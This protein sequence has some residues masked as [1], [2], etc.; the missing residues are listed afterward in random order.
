M[1]SVDGD[2][3]TGSTRVVLIVD[4]DTISRMLLQHMVSAQGYEV[5]EADSVDPALAVLE[6]TAVDLIICDYVMPGKDGLDL[7]ETMPD[8]TIPFV[9]LTGALDES[10][11]NDT[12]VERVSAYLTKPVASDRLQEV[13]EQMLQRTAPS[14]I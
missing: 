1:L 6:T 14:T 8:Q 12:R 10:E 11:L 3:S 9:L 13:V 4:D 7:L 2:P 5:V